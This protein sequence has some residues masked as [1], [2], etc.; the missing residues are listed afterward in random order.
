[1]N[2]YHKDANLEKGIYCVSPT[3]SKNISGL[4]GLG[5]LN[6]WSTEHVLGGEMSVWQ[7]NGGYTSSHLRPK[8]QDLWHQVEPGG[9]LGQEDVW[10]SHNGGSPSLGVHWL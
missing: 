6:R 5:K 3:S 2:A 9:A 4:Q 7:G 1:M 10:V 8:T